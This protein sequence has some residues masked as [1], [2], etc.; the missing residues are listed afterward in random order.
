MAFAMDLGRY[1]DLEWHSGSDG[2]H[3][4]PGVIQGPVLVSFI[5]AVEN[6]VALPVTVC[7]D[8]KSRAP[9]LPEGVCNNLNGPL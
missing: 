4:G 7:G 3:E 9:P 1:S 8:S 6:I 2:E 5:L